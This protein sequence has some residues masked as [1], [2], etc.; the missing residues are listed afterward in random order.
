MPL[1]SSLAASSHFAW[2]QCLQASHSSSPFS[3]PV[4]LFSCRLNFWCCWAANTSCQVSGIVKNPHNFFVLQNLLK[5]WYSHIT[6]SSFSYFYLINKDIPFFLFEDKRLPSIISIH[7][8]PGSR[9]F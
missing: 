8:L 4:T 7:V 5:L 9:L 6:V 2:C 1:L 3:Y